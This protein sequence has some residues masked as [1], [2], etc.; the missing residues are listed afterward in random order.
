MIGIIDLKTVHKEPTS[1][2]NLHLRLF[3]GEVY[4]K[5]YKNQNSKPPESKMTAFETINTPK[6]IS[7][8]F[9]CQKN[10]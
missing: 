6:L 5:N 2:K 1:L 10:S 9:E 7:R 4:S 3:N 8:K